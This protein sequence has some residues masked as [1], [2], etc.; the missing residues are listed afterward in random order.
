MICHDT[1]PDEE[2]DQFYFESDHLAL[3]GNKDYTALLKAI[4][5]LEAQRT[6]AIED[7]DKLMENREKA[8][9]DPI[10][11]VAQLQNGELP[12]L[13]GPQKIADIPSIDWSKYNIGALDNNKLKPQ[14]RH[15]QTS[16]VPQVKQEQDDGKVKFCFAV[17]NSNNKLTRSNCRFWSEDERLTSP[18]Q[19]LSINC[20]QRRNR[21]DWSNFSL[22]IHRKK[23]R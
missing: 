9:Q 13:P 2:P 22:S 8:L 1:K 6:Q 7:L 5:T 10:S 16:N 11:F 23:L 17:N 12:E 19:K 20:G 4:V 14:T 18:S 21:G 15:G 3:K